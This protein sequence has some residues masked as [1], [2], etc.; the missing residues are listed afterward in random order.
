MCLTISGRISMYDRQ[1]YFLVSPVIYRSYVATGHCILCQHI[2][3]CFVCLLL[4]SGSH[5]LNFL[6]NECHLYITWMRLSGVYLI[7][8]SY[9]FGFISVIVHIM[10]KIKA[11]KKT[12]I[13]LCKCGVYKFLFIC[14]FGI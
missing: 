4:P 1:C 14:N 13:E 9:N 5:Y 12:I 7:L 2:R 8:Y 6:R 10:K 11:Q 3:E